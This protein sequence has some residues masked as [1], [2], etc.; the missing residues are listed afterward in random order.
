[1]NFA[2]WYDL[3]ILASI[4]IP[5]MKILISNDDGYQAP[6]LQLLASALSEIAQIT[7]VAPDK[8]R[9]GSSNSLTLDRP[10]SLNRAANGF[11]HVN[12]TPADCVH[13]ALTSIL[14]SPQILSC[15][16]S[17]KGKIWATILCIQ[18]Q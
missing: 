14:E 8:N 17:I 6:G 5:D 1:L 16:A 3:C 13:I 7:V 15:R 12:G 18:E 9:S 2:I 11:Y 4:K 10:L